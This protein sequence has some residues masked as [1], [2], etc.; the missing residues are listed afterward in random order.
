M[1]PVDELDDT[2][3]QDITSI[4]KEKDYYGLLNIPKTVSFV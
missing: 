3:I 4:T 2:N 1:N